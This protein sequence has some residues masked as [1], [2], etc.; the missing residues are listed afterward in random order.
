M[1]RKAQRAG[2]VSLVSWMKMQKNLNI[3]IKKDMTWNNPWYVTRIVV[4]F[5]HNLNI[6]KA[7]FEL[8]ATIA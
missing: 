4:I 8:I 6:S 3:N 1:L 5:E 7:Y 2:V